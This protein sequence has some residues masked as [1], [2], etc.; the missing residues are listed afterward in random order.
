MSWHF[1]QGQEEAFWAATSSD[2]APAVLLNLI[3]TLEA[4]C[5]LDSAMASCPASRSG[6]TLKPSTDTRGKDQSTCAV[7]DFPVRT[8]AAPDGGQASKV[9]KAASGARWP[10]SFARFD[11]VSSSWRTAQ[12]S[13]LGGLELYSET[14]PR[15]GMMLDGACWEHTTLAPP[16]KE[17]G[18]G[19]LPTPKAAEERGEAYTMETSFRHWSEG[20]HQVSLSQV[21]RDPRMWPTPVAD[22]DRTTD[23]AQ[24]GRSLGAEVRRWPTPTAHNAIEGG[25]PAEGTR[26]TTSLCWEAQRRPR[27][28][29]TPQASD[30]R[31]RGNLSTPSIHR[32]IAKG[33][34]ISLSMS[35]SPTSG[36]LNPTWVAWLMG[37]PVGWTDLNALETAKFQQWRRS[38]GLPSGGRRER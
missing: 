15:W 11:P 36:K 3:P 37:W 17:I 23:Y 2:G 30:N 5:S 27:Q 34:Q 6:M 28:W 33:K 10:G 12:C 22:G 21:V 8:L 18:S 4:S 35:V 38:H 7:A 16:T 13:L 14:W 32:R 20:S 1:L 24:G 25:Y 19:F 9:K 26:V 31:D 29:P